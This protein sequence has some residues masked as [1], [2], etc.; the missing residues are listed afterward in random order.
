MAHYVIYTR[1]GAGYVKRVRDFSSHYPHQ[2]L[3]RYFHKELLV[4][5][6][7]HIVFWANREGPS[8]GV[9]PQSGG[10]Q[11]PPDQERVLAG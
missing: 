4:G 6:P 8:M 1:T 3:H 7:E 9:A 10:K 11:N 5:F 2:L